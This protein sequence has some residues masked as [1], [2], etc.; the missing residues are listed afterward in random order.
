MRRG[1]QPTNSFGFMDGGI[2]ALYLEHF[3]PEIQ[4][5]VRRQIF[6]HHAVELLVGAADIVETGAASIPFL[7]AAPPCG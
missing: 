5:R 6:E 7:I 1:G 2:D 3:S 4:L